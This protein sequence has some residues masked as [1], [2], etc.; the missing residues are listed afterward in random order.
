MS[1]LPCFRIHLFIISLFAVF[2]T[3][4]LLA[5]DKPYDMTDIVDSGSAPTAAQVDADFDT[6]Y[7]WVNDLGD[8]TQI[9]TK[10]SS[11]TLTISERGVIECSGNTTITM[12]AVANIGYL[13]Y[14]VKTD[15]SATT[16]TIDG[17]DGNINDTA[18]ITLNTK[19]EKAVLVSNGTRYLL[20]SGT[21]GAN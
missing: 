6:L 13:F 2:S 18:T 8:L 16:C 4:Y 1:K 20:L 11:A 9:T 21:S 19:W 5:L 7:D 3:A 14:I 17:N 15:S 10:S 12:P